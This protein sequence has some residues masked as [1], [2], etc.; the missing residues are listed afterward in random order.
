[1]AAPRMQPMGR[2]LTDPVHQRPRAPQPPKAAVDDGFQT[3]VRKKKAQKK[4]LVEGKG[5]LVIPVERDLSGFTVVTGKKKKKAK[6]V[7]PRPSVDTSHTVYVNGLGIAT[8]IRRRELAMVM[9]QFGKVLD[10]TILQNPDGESYAFVNFATQ[11]ALWK[12]CQQDKK[13][14]IRGA[15]LELKPRAQRLGGQRF[16]NQ[17]GRGRMVNNGPARPVRN[18]RAPVAAAPPKRKTPIPSTINPNTVPTTYDE[19]YSI[20]FNRKYSSREVYVIG[21]PK[22]CEKL[23]PGIKRAFTNVTGI[24]YVGIN[25]VCNDSVMCEY[26]TVEDAQVAACK[27]NNVVLPQRRWRLHSHINLKRSPEY[28]AAIKKLE[29]FRGRLGPKAAN[30]KTKELEMIDSKFRSVWLGGISHAIACSEIYNA[31]AKYWRIEKVTLPHKGYAN[32]AGHGFVMFTDFRSAR[33]AINSFKENKKLFA[34]EGFDRWQV[35]LCTRKLEHKFAHAGVVAT[36]G[37]PSELFAKEVYGVTKANWDFVPKPQ[38]PPKPPKRVTTS[39]KKT[40]KKRAT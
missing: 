37:G 9:G 29:N 40:N 35:N 22:T 4:G 12:C 16:N 5:L 30:I 21:V 31:F 20:G 17:R 13:I 10:V 3:V 24:T 2:S 25:R 28:K 34:L 7:G 14:I 36:D 23:G 32:R 26:A 39:K 19:Q 1:V 18:V 6:P 38:G 11:E 8:D 33:D 27:L 15:M